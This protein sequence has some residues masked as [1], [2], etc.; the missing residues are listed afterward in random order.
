MREIEIGCKVTDAGH[1]ENFGQSEVDELL[2]QGWRVATIRA[3]GALMRRNQDG[4]KGMDW[5]FIGF[6]MMVEFEPPENNSQSAR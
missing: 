5:G 1:M 4:P 3:R 6:A 2:K